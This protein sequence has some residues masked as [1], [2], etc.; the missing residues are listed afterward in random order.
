MAL[1]NIHNL[2]PCVALTCPGAYK[3]L[4]VARS[5]STSHPGSLVQG[6]GLLQRRH[7]GPLREA[8]EDPN[9]SPPTQRLAQHWQA[10]AAHP[11]NGKWNPP[12]VPVSPP[13]S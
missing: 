3:G 10:A 13:L 7:T 8:G 2:C 9:C 5:T 4:L 11:C 1:K 12:H 6:A